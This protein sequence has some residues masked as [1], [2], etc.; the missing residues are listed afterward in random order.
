[1]SSALNLRPDFGP[2]II[3]AI[4][5][6][7]RLGPWDL[8]VVQ[9]VAAARFAA[10]NG[11]RHLVDREFRPEELG[12]CGTDYGPTGWGSLLDHSIWFAAGRRNVAIVSQPYD[13]PEIEFFRCAQQAGL[14]AHVP[15]NRLASFHNP[16]VTKF[17]VLTQPGIIVR[18]LPEQEE[19]A[20]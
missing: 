8:K 3:Q 7:Q 1:V 2:N 4:T 17:F 10:E 6:R 20:Q 11:W 13:L 9:D 5:A 15:P 12:K 18:W 19:G 14:V 16:G